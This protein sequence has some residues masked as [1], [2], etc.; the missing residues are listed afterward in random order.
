MYYLEMGGKKKPEYLNKEWTAKT[1][2][3]IESLTV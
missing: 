1:S 2:L 3:D